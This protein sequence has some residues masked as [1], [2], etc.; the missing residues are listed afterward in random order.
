M[1]NDTEPQ[2]APTRKRLRVSVSA[3]QF[4]AIALLLR[5]P[6]ESASREL[7]R[8]H[9]VDGI[10]L[11]DAAKLTGIGIPA[12]YKALRRFKEVMELAQIAAGPPGTLPQPLRVSDEQFE[13]LAALRRMPAKSSSRELARMHAVDGIPIKEAVDRT[14]ISLVG[15]YKAVQRLRKALDLARTTVGL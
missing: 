5:M 7:V 8:R 12:G 9:V 10:P 15:G 1:D 6:V 11:K 4:E 13:A 14:G 2:K 3:A